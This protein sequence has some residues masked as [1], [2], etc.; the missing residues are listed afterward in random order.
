MAIDKLATW[1]SNGAHP[2]AEP[3]QCQDQVRHYQADH[4]R[5]QSQRCATRTRGGRGKQDNR[6]GVAAPTSTPTPM[7]ARR[8]NWRV[9]GCS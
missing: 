9:E 4:E 5:E 2:T 7:A 8:D 1:N 3:E 6:V